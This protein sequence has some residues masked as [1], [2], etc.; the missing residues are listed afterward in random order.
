MT[1]CTM[2]TIIEG[3]TLVRK[4]INTNTRKAMTTALGTAARGDRAKKKWQLLVQVGSQNIS[5]LA[6]SAQSGALVCSSAMIAGLMTIR[7]DREP[8]WW[9]VPCFEACVARR[10]TSRAYQS[11]HGDHSAFGVEIPAID[12]MINVRPSEIA[13]MLQDHAREREVSAR[14]S[15]FQALKPR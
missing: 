2:R 7:A 11:R 12:L 1:K 15:G 5:L 8:R 14:S 9:A 3:S 13:Q 4:A 6:W 10:T